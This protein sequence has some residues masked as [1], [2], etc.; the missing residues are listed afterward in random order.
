MKR[1]IAIFLCIITCLYCSGCS[2]DYAHE[3]NAVGG[4]DVGYSEK[5]TDA[6]LSTYNWDGTDEA[7]HIV[8]PE[9]YNGIP[10]TTFGGFYGRGVPRSCDIEPTDDAKKI[11]CEEADEWFH[12][13]GIPDGEFEEFTTIYF[14]VHISKNIEKIETLHL[15]GFIGA[16]Y[17]K[18][19]VD[20]RKTFIILCNVTCDE[21]NKVFYAKDGKLY[22]KRSGSLVEDIFYYDFDW[23]DY[24]DDY[25][26]KNKDEW[27]RNSMF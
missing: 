21:N 13:S 19:G 22:Y 15:G 25:V 9:E 7:T 5:L 11:L 12:I 26:E 6:F 2:F 17:T 18:D 27:I 10:I 1:L 16:E 4:F 24:V 3:N 8:V 20:Y 23:D 14:D